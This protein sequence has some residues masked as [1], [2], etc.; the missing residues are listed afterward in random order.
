MK[1]TGV[2]T[3]LYELD[4]TR[5]LGDA[6]SPAGR[7]RAAQVAVFIDTDD[8]MT[9]L[10]I[11]SPAA[12]SHIHSF[13]DN[14]LVGCDPRGVRGLW[15]KMVDFVFKGGNNGIANDAICA[16]DMA[17]WDLKAKAAGEPLW[18]LLGATTGKVK[19]YASG[20]DL[21]L[22]DE[23]IGAFYSR[24]AHLGISAG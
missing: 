22:T 3:V 16:I 23:E 10:G 7:K 8:G 1:I 5:L 6:N 12:R 17:L 4:L 13:V 15:Q 2:R 24:M 19:A 9:G 21:P 11:G 18:R 20:I 14:L